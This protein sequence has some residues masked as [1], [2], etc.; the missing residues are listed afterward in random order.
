MNFDTGRPGVRHRIPDRLS[1]DE[2]QIPVEAL[3]QQ[4][5]R[6]LDFD[7]DGNT[8]FASHA[9]REIFE[10]ATKAIG[11]GIVTEVRKSLPRFIKRETELDT[12][13][14]QK[15]HHGR[16]FGTDKTSRRFE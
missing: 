5:G 9:E 8:R 4:Q 15:L 2:K 12:G 16:V 10:G 13:A 3:G 7:I 14:V 6:A 11:E 1:G